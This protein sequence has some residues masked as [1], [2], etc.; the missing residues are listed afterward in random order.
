MEVKNTAVAAKGDCIMKNVLN[1]HQHLRLS[2]NNYRLCNI[3]KEPL[4]T[5]DESSLNVLVTEKITAAAKGLGY[6]V[7]TKISSNH[8]PL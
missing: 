6:T 3:F 7:A 4:S 2:K 1:K 5:L 8:K